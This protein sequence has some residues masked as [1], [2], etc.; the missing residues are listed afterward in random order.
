[1][2]LYY[3][4]KMPNKNRKQIRIRN[5]NNNNNDNSNKNKIP[6]EDLNGNVRHHILFQLHFLFDLQVLRSYEHVHCTCLRAALTY[7]MTVA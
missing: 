4:Y 1:M 3:T 7:L 2:Q 6:H 5:N